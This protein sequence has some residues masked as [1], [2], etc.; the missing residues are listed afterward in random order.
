MGLRWLPLAGFVAACA[1]TPA[2]VQVDREA[3]LA[4]GQR[5]VFHAAHGCEV[6]FERVVEDG[7]CPRGRQCA[8]SNPVRVSVRITCAGSARSEELAV[9]D[10]DVGE[11][12][13]QGVRSCAP[14]D[15]AVLRLRDVT[16]YPGASSERTRAVL[17]VEG[18]CGG[19]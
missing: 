12:R 8:A 6:L 9:L 17:V 14:I 19:P 16:P 18:R 4:L 10:R 1:A 11:P 15:G 13:M 7:R 2:R 3:A 5:A